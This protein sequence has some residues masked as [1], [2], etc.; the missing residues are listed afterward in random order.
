MNSSGDV[1]RSISILSA[2]ITQ[3]NLIA[4]D[5][6][7]AFFSGTVVNDSGVRTRSG[8]CLKTG[9]DVIFLCSE[10]KPKLYLEKNVIYC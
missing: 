8:Y 3:I 9:S 7:I 6:T 4:S 2:G 1:C 5:R 10:F